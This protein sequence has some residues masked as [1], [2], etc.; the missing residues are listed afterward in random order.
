MRIFLRFFTL[1]NDG[2][3]PSLNQLIAIALGQRL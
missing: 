2:R 1:G 3:T